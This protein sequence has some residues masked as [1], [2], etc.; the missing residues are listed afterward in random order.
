MAAKMKICDVCKRVHS[1]INHAI[2]HEINGTYYDLCHKHKEQAADVVQFALAVF[3]TA[4]DLKPAE[5]AKRLTA[6]RVAD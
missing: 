5:I 1:D 4:P 6:W 2:S 3:A